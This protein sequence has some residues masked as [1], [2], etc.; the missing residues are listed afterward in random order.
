[1]KIFAD[2]LKE[3]RIEKGLSQRQLATETKLSQASIAKWELDQRSPI[4]EYVVILSSYFG[5]SS[6][7]LLGLED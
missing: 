6:D 5:V 7:Y 2:R 3:L 1:M 4:A